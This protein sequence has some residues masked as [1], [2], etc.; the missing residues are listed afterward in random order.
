MADET[1]TS[2]AA[3][4]VKG[5]DLG[6]QLSLPLPLTP[7]LELDDLAPGAHNAKA[8]ALIGG[9]PQDWPLPWAA[10]W[11]PPASGKSALA[12]I[13][14][15]RAHAQVLKIGGAAAGEPSSGL[16][17]SALCNTVL[18]LEEL[19]SLPQALEEPVFHLMNNLRAAGFSLLILARQAPARWP[20][21]LPDLA[22][23]LRAVLAVE[24][25]EGDQAFLEV[26]L[27]ALAAQFELD[28]RPE[29]RAYLVQRLPRSAEA[30]LAIIQLLAGRTRAV[31]VP[32][33][34]AVLE[35]WQSR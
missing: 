14:A 23:R 18:D 16:L 13:W 20:V 32:Q 4:R 12:E 5:E 3:G 21:G 26:L 10:L 25:G 27:V 1:D 9:W 30:C 17:Q 2:K 33:A 31:T 15:R 29:A 11:G 22:S 8:L 19:E 7:E 34:R 35:D 28:M 24:I 6:R